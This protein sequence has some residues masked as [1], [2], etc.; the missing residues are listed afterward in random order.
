MEFYELSNGLSIPKIGFGIHHL[1]EGQLAVDT[2]YEAIKAGWRLLETASSFFNEKSLGLGIEKALNENIVKREDLIISTKLQDEMQGYEYTH[3]AFQNSLEKL[4]VDYIDIFAI[5]LPLIMEEDWQTPLIDSWRAMENLYDEGKICVLALSNFA[6]KHLEFL[7]ENAR[8][9]PMIN[10]L[11]IHPRFHQYGLQKF[12]KK[13]NILVS[14]WRS[15]EYGKICYNET[16]MKIAR[17]LEKTPAQIVLR[18]HI[19]QNRLPITRTTHIDRMNENLN[20]FDFNLD[21]NE[22][23][24]INNLKDPLF[25]SNQWPTEAI[26]THGGINE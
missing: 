20:I 12:C 18:W 4:G 9:K 19:Q 26:R 16:I 8:I 1:D 5:R 7:L 25:K 24:I 10:Q 21:E 3:Q 14:S 17:K 11:E 15:L 23:N 2:T 13:N 22:M 6:A